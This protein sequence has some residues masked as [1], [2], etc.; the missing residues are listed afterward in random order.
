MKVVSIHS[1]KGGAGK[2]AVA[3]LIAGALVRRGRRVCVIDLDFMGAGIDPAIKLSKPK[4]Y[5]E[6]AL[7]AAPGSRDEPR[8]ADL[9]ALHGIEGSPQP[10]ACILNTGRATSGTRKTKYSDL[11]KRI[12]NMLELE[13]NTGFIENGLTRLLDKLAEGYEYVL[14]D[15][16]PSLTGVSEVAFRIEMARPVDE[17]AV[18]LAATADRAHVYGLLKEMNRRSKAKDKTLRPENMALVINMVE[19]DAKERPYRSTLDSFAML[20]EELERDPVVGNE[21]PTLLHVFQ[22]THYC[23][24]LWHRTM[25]NFSAIASEG[26]VP[27][28]PRGVIMHN[29]TSLCEEFFEPG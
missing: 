12:L 6:E 27:P 15:C 3:L 2:T 26:R 11:H 13:D 28:W 24:I 25:A 23:R 18:F 9:V 17:S 14:L 7:M 8:P 1:H 16:H 10:I 21:A 29:G 5:L 19:E 4:R 20:G 22:P